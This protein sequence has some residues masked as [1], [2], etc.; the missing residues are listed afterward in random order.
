MCLT[1]YSKEVVLVESLGLESLGLDS[2]GPLEE[3]M[4]GFLAL[5]EGTKKLVAVGLK[6]S[7]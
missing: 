2:V 6:L 7:T 1:P 4:E 5:L 3:E